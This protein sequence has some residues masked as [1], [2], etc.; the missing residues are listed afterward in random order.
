LASYLK[1]GNKPT[2]FERCFVIFCLCKFVFLLYNF[3]VLKRI[4]IYAALSESR[5]S[6][7]ETLAQLLLPRH[8]LFLLFILFFLM[9]KIL[10]KNKNFFLFVF[11]SF[12]ACYITV[13]AKNSYG[14]VFVCFFIFFYI[15]FVMKHAW[16]IIHLSFM[17]S[18]KVFVSFFLLKYIHVVS[19]CYL[20]PFKNGGLFCLFFPLSFPFFI[21]LIS[22]KICYIF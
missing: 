7:D 11:Q 2:I 6:D 4:F 14:R 9:T 20:R 16:F 10:C 13:L 18:L 22:K 15:F 21:F 1:A 3:V 19:H 8:N 17:Y 5:T 12:F